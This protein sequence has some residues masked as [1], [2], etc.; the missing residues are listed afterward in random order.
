MLD[1]EVKEEDVLVQKL[2]SI[3]F[4][5]GRITTDLKTAVLSNFFEK[6]TSLRPCTHHREIWSKLVFSPPLHLI[7]YTFN[8]F[9]LN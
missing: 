7:N 8:S 6:G 2:G 1:G 9:S 4:R 5:E 3:T